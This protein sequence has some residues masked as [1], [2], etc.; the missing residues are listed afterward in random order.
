MS[1]K[2]VLFDKFSAEGNQEDIWDDRA[3][4]RAYDRSI[5]KLKKEL[6][7]KLNVAEAPTT[8]ISDKTATETNRQRDEHEE[9]ESEY[10]DENEEQDEEVEEDDEGEEPDEDDKYYDTANCDFKKRENPNEWSLN[11]LCM[12]VY[13]R[14]GLV[15]PAKIIK[16]NAANDSDDEAQ[17]RTKCTVQYLYY[18][19]EEQK[20]L[21]ELY[22]YVDSDRT[23]DKCKNSTTT[24]TTNEPKKTN[25]SFNPLKNFIPPPPMPAMMDMKSL[26]G[27]QDD[28]LY[29]M[30]IS[31]YMSGF[32]TGYYMALKNDQSSGS[33]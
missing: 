33:C 24:E 8:S 21:D 12:A 27:N 32:H 9:E 15:Y 14:D 13:S 31:W 26:T 19:N 4:I 11:D 20:Y 3:L 2:K 1:S 22:L 18:L 5:N 29:S 25:V 16:I 17:K 10:E 30:L 6:D 23:D 7:R 28:A